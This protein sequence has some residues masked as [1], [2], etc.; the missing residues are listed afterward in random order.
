M[1]EQQG[2]EQEAIEPEEY[3]IEFGFDVNDFNIE[4]PSLDFPDLF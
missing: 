2:I 4:M 3:D 1:Q